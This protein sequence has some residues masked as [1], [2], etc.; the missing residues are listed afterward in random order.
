MV[1]EPDVERAEGERQSGERRGPLERAVA[2]R[3]RP[4]ERQAGARG[5]PGASHQ[6]GGD[7][8]CGDLV[9]AVPRDETRSLRSGTMR[10]PVAAASTRASAPPASAP[11]T[12]R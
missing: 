6:A 9:H 2:R 12:T 4:A 10:A 1:R 5:A 3:L 8:A 11:A 7:R